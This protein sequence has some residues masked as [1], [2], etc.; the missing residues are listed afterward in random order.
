[1]AGRR[2]ID[3]EELRKEKQ[4]CIELKVGSTSEVFDLICSFV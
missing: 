2:I 1:M 4:K 3:A